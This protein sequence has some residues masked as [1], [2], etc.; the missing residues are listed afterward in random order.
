MTDA[1]QQLV[2]E[3]TPQDVAALLRARTKDSHG[4]E[5][6]T[7]TDD[8]RPTTAQV[9]EQI[10]IARTLVRLDVGGIPDACQ[11]GG[12]AVVALLASL[13]VEQS[14]WPEQVQSERSAYDRLLALY[15]QARLGLVACVAGNQPG[16]EGTA[17][18][19]AYDVCTPLQPCGGDWPWDWWQ[20][21][22]DQVP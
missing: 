14:Y 2:V 1:Q 8:T 12:E 4:A 7:W 9:Q 16:G 5:L 18:W 10:D 11:E 20:R 19:R 3:A 22:L 13:L 15:E 21:N 6:G 17:S